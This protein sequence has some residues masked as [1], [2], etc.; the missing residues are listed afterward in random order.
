MKH[1]RLRRI[2]TAGDGGTFRGVSEVPAFNGPRYY[3]VFFD[4]PKTGS[5]MTMRLKGL[6]AKAVREHIKE[7]NVKFGVNS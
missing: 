4:S 3:F 5:T 6:T 2:I 7:S 1:Q